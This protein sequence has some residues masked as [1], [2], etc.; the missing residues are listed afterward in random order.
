[1]R[2]PT[3]PRRSGEP[4]IAPGVYAS[5][6]ELARLEHKASGFSFLPRQPVHSLLTGRHVSRVRGRGLDFEELR[7]Y[8][9][10]DDVRTID[11]RVTQ[12]TGTPHVR[13]FTEERDRPAILAVDQRLNMFFGTQ[14]AMK[15]VA[16]AELAA[17]AA[18]RVFAQGDRVGG[19]V[20]N[21]REPIVIGPHRSRQRVMQLLGTVVEMNRELRVDA[22]VEPDAAMLNQV[23]ENVARTVTH[24][25][26]VMVIS[27]FFGQDEDTH[28][29]LTIMAQHNDVICALLYDPI[30]VELPDAGRLVVSDGDL[31]LELDTSQGRRRSAL[32]EYFDADL[33]RTKNELAR[34]GVPVLLIHTALDPAEQIRQQLG[35]VPRGGG[36][37]R[38]Q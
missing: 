3:V 28:R 11:W 35:Y 21:D 30:K 29:L 1:M 23:L 6:D 2:Y 36:P 38:A 5:L 13:V 26:L 27:D 8:L 10:G 22:P 14:T 9:P 12:R 7:R 17:L 32:S 4:D 16:A 25:A 20:F 31:Q 37:R 34:V 24:D 33:K 19:V 15:S 18:W